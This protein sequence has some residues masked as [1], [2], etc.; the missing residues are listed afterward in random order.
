MVHFS[1]SIFTTLIIGFICFLAATQTYAQDFQQRV[2]R[3]QRIEKNA[4]KRDP[5]YRYLD[6]KWWYQKKSGDW[7]RWDGQQWVDRPAGDTDEPGPQS[8]RKA[9]PTRTMT[10]EELQNTPTIFDLFDSFIGDLDRMVGPG[11]RRGR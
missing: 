5:R 7:V 1:R 4:Q 11:R 6:G 9:P 8:L 2:A 3:E 10:T